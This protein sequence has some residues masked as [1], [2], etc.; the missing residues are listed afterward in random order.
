MH[1]MISHI[2]LSIKGNSKIA[3]EHAAHHGLTIRSHHPDDE[4]N[5][6][7]IC[8]VT[9]SEKNWLIAEKWFETTERIL[10]S[11]NPV[12][13]IGTLMF[14]TTV[15]TCNPDEADGFFH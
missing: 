8:E 9:Y 5:D 13:P 12:Y 11:P 2:A 4:D 6:Y 1:Y 14:Y 15:D 10:D 3:L 7:T